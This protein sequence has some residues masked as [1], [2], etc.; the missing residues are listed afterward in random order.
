MQLCV[1]FRFKFYHCFYDICRSLFF[2][3]QR[4]TKLLE[5]WL[6]NTF[7]YNDVVM[8]VIVLFIEL[9]ETMIRGTTL[10]IEGYFFWYRSRIWNSWW[11]NTLFHG[12]RFNL[13]II[14]YQYNYNAVCFHET[15]TDVNVGLFLFITSFCCFFLVL[16]YTCWFS[17]IMSCVYNICYNINLLKKTS[18]VFYSAYQ[19]QNLL[20]N[21]CLSPLTLWVRTPFRRGRVLNTLCDKVCQWPATDWWFSPGTPV[22]SNNK[23]DLHD[24]TEILLKV[25]LNTINLI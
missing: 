8:P 11:E 16:V 12:F 10:I 15:D 22:S 19:L 17:N 4:F 13:Q 9:Y 25:E 14:K 21:Q 6:L 20:Q 7:L 23:T 2:L 24:V 18:F 5:L 1:S 3:V